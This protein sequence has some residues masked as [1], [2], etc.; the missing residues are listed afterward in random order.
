VRGIGQSL[1]VTT[2]CAF[3]VPWG[4]TLSSKKGLSPV[5]RL[6]PFDFAVGADQ[7]LVEQQVDRPLLLVPFTLS[8]Q[9]VSWWW[10]DGEAKSLQRH[11]QL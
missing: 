9:P 11:V 7:D 1:G 10:L 5:L 4:H 3:E 8:G 2:W 6:N